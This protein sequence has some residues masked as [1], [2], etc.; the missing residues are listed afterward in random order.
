[1]HGCFIIFSLKKKDI[2]LYKTRFL[3]YFFHATERFEEEYLGCVKTKSS[4][5][6]V[7]HSTSHLKSIDVLI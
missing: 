4:Y 6:L 2:V 7:R 3:Y 1:M 5:W